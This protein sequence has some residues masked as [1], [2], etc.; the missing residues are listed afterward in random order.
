VIY[1]KYK[2][3]VCT[4]QSHR[5][6]FKPGFFSNK[7]SYMSLLSSL[8]SVRQMIFFTGYGNGSSELGVYKTKCMS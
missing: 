5:F 3:D 2:V 1:S 6:Y 7:S 8:N 4:P